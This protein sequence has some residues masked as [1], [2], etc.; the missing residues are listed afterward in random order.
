M[1][2]PAPKP[3]L[4][5]KPAEPALV[6]RDRAKMDK[7]RAEALNPESAYEATLFRLVPAVADELD[8]KGK[9]T[10][11]RVIVKDKW[12]AVKV[13]MR[14][15]PAEVTVLEKSVSLSVARSAV[16]IARSR[17]TFEADTG[18]DP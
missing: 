16:R 5:S 14:G 4:P 7:L 8:A 10:G 18:R 6:L 12:N 17:N 3:K 9:P 15:A 1:A 2:Q 11:K 13:V